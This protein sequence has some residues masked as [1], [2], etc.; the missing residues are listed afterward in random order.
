[1]TTRRRYLAIAFFVGFTSLVY[2]VYSAKVLFLYFVESTHAVAVTLSAFLAGLGTSAL[3]CSRFAKEERGRAH[4][5]LVVLLVSATIYS[6]LILRHH[7]VI[8]WIVERAH[9]AFGTGFASDVCRILFSWVYL[10]VPGLFIGGAFPILTGLYVTD[11]DAKTR[12]A[13]VVYFWDTVGAIVGALAAGFVLLPWLG[14]RRTVLVPG[15]I[16]LFVVSALLERRAARAVAAAAAVGCLVLALLDGGGRS[17]LDDSDKVVVALEA[18]MGAPLGS[19]IAREE[20]PFGPITVRTGTLGKPGNRALF[21]GLRGMC[22][23]LSGA[24]ETYLATTTLIGLKPGA[25][26]LNIGLGCGLTAGTLAA[27]P[28][29]AVL[30]IA[31]INPVVARM[32][33]SQ[34][35]EAN[36]HVLDLA[37]TH[38]FIE[39]GAELLRE[40]DRIY[41]AVVIDVEEPAIVHSSLLYTREYFEIIRHKLAQGG[42]LALWMVG[43]NP[44]DN[45]I[46]WNT[47]RSVFPHVALRVSEQVPNSSFFASMVELP[48]PAARGI[49]A[50]MIENMQAVGVDAVNTIDNRALER[51]FDVRRAFALPRDYDEPVFSDA[52]RARARP[53]P[54][55]SAPM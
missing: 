51:H 38:L 20:S 52:E 36:G 18:R 9:R 27:S 41:D 4:A 53:A 22:Y 17:A 46:L 33:R 14:L 16:N 44:Y 24:S 55:T 35:G 25:R 31:E 34:F 1:M 5:V 40:T 48:F 49:A 45:R 29:V 43:Q 47:L 26:V 12:D 3:F 54:A 42:I 6:L 50:R 10:F 32:A 28:K 2:E 23:S 39:D 11:L 37:K 7:E 15:A 19:V 30:E 21:I 13:G 8:P